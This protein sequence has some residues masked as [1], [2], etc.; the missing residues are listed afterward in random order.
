MEEIIF[1]NKIRIVRKTRGVAMQDVAKLLGISLSAISKIEK[2]YRRIDQEQLIK[3]VNLLKCEANDVLISEKDKDDSDVIKTWKNESEKRVK[4]NEYNGLKILGAALRHIRSQKNLTLLEVAEKALMT[5]SVY[6]R[7]EMG[8][9]EISEKEFASIAQALGVPVNQLFEEIYELNNS[10]SLDKFIQKGALK[11]RAMAKPSSGAPQDIFGLAG[12]S[13]SVKLQG[14]FKA[15]H[16]QLYG[17]ADHDGGIIINKEETANPEDIQQVRL[18]VQS[19]NPN[20]TI[21]DAA[22]PIFVEKYQQI[23]GKKVL[24]VEDGPTL[25]HGGMK[26]GA[27]LVAAQKFGAGEIIDP[28]PYAKGSLL[29]T[30]KKFNHL[31]NILPAMGYGAKQM[32]EL[33]E[34][35]NATPV[36]LV[37]IG[38][39]ID[40]TRVI[41][42]NK[43]ALRVQYELQ[44]IGKPDLED[45]LQD[46]IRKHNI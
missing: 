29:S 22:S 15:R 31:D 37:I 3:I 35:I 25:T 38:T 28:R 14:M 8:Q 10:G 33:E 6:H 18:R 41:K 45:V 1:P 17:R 12:S 36:D 24:V 43:P 23:K 19:L 46:F 4:A 9:R 7:I 40:L 2:G 11:L 42:I 32:K 5:L 39:P 20:A 26:Y 21:I 30:Y 16:I 27:G 44:E 13:Y 34:S